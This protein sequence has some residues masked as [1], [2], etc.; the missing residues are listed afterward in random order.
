ML[1]GTETRRFSVAADSLADASALAD[2]RRMS[3]QGGGSSAKSGGGGASVSGEGGDAAS[4]SSKAPPKPKPK[5]DKVRRALGR[6]LQR[7]FTKVGTRAPQHTCKSRVSL[8]AEIRTMRRPPPPCNTTR[9]NPQQHNNTTAHQRNSTATHNLTPT[10][11]SFLRTRSKS[12][13]LVTVLVQA[14]HRP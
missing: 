3:V 13:S 4:V 10:R 12:A 14:W 1:P 6:K 11:V 9:N 5:V 7:Q 2:A 8:G